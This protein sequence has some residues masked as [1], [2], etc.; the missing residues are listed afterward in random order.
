MCV[1]IDQYAST[2]RRVLRRCD[3]S[4][5]AREEATANRQ[6]NRVTQRVVTGN[7]AALLSEDAAA[8]IRAL[9][10]SRLNNLMV[11]LDAV[12]PG[13]STQLLSDPRSGNIREL[14]GLHNNVFTDTRDRSNEAAQAINGFH[15]DPRAVEQVQMAAAL[16][17]RALVENLDDLDE[18]TREADL[19][20]IDTRLASISSGTM[21][22][23][24]PRTK[25]DE[26]SP[27][28]KKF[29]TEHDLDD[30]VAISDVQQRMSDRIFADLTEQAVAAA[31]PRGFSDEFDQ[32]LRN[33]DRNVTERTV[34]VQDLIQAGEKLEISPDVLLMRDAEGNGYVHVEGM[35]FRVGQDDRV[36]D[37]LRRLPDIDTEKWGM[38]APSSSMT[39]GMNTVVQSMLVGDGPRAKTLRTAARRHLLQRAFY[40]DVKSSY[41]LDSDG[42]QVLMPGKAR[43]YT[44][45]RI[46]SLT[47]GRHLDAGENVAR[48]E[49]FDIQRNLRFA[50]AARSA[51]IDNLPEELRADRAQEAKLKPY[52]GK[53]LAS[54]RDDVQRYGFRIGHPENTLSR[55]YPA[56]A[57]MEVDWSATSAVPDV[58][59]GRPLSKEH[60]QVRE[61]GSEMVAEANQI[62]R[63]GRNPELVDTSALLSSAKLA[64]AFD[65]FLRVGKEERKPQVLTANHTIPSSFI[66]REAEFFSSAFPKGGAVVTKGYTLARS[67]D[68]VSTPTK[69]RYRVRYFTSDGM[70]VKG[71]SIIGGGTQFRVLDVVESDGVTEVR[72]VADQVAAKM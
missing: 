18:E 30:M 35:T 59:A 64:T 29:Y 70:P 49:G 39:P 19:R 5:H 58:P 38:V 31:A 50:T 68:A 3:V 51:V 71:G 23:P 27:E 69:G 8:A 56:A 26:L 32:A 20:R 62:D 9:P 34:Q 13:I 21:R 47:H 72:M 54:D 12:Q 11:S 67:D 22:A 28:A 6:R 44:A 1:T 48:V 2:N 60:A 61:F 16:A 4:E 15:R 10:P 33:V 46:A 14:P 66:G 36:A 65:A 42:N 45:S 41:T 37:V 52:R 53:V 57:N 7:A 63:S 55:D 25:F 43:R 40:G 17:E 24:A